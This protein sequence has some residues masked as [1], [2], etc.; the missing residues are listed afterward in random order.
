MCTSVIYRRVCRVIYRW[1]FTGVYVGHLQVCVR[2]FTGVCVRSFTGVYVR[3]ALAATATHVAAPHELAGAA[4]DV[5]H[6]PGV[7]ATPAAQQAA[8]V[9]PAGRPA[10]GPA[11]GAQAAAPRVLQ[12]VVGRLVE[13]EEAV[14]LQR[15][16]AA[17]LVLA[18][19]LLPGEALQDLH[20]VLEALLQDRPHALERR[21]GPPAGLHR[22]GAR[23]AVATAVLHHGSVDGLGEEHG[24]VSRHGSV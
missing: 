20:A 13:V 24:T 7:V 18:A 2:S 16:A 14:P 5:P 21:Q 9:R 8:A 4:R 23:H 3:H 19:D 11:A 22:A 6:H 15:H 12:A 1:L 10:A 17:H